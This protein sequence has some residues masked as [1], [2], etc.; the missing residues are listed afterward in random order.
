MARFRATVGNLCFLMMFMILGL[1]VSVAIAISAMPKEGDA[2]ISIGGLVM[3][4]LMGSCFTL[5][6]VLISFTALSPI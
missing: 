6:G 1:A 3:P 5:I 4:I 2:W